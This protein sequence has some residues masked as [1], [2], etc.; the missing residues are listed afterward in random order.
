M[1]GMYEI[2]PLGVKFKK[3]TPPQ[4]TTTKTSPPATSPSGE[5]NTYLFPTVGED[6]DAL[7]FSNT[8]N[9]VPSIKQ[10]SLLSDWL[11]KLKGVSN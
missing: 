5:D 11:N 2:C 3:H 4:K 9:V 6:S 1:N 10:Q 7:V 8:K